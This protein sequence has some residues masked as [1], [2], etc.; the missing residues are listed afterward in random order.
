MDEQMISGLPRVLVFFPPLGAR[1]GGACL[2]ICH[3]VMY[4]DTPTP[5]GPVSGGKIE[6]EKKKCSR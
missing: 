5:Y 1:G 6:E 3:L 4:Q 2:L